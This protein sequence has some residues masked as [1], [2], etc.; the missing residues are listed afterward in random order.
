MAT[1]QQILAGISYPYRV[2]GQGEPAGAKGIDVVRSDLIVLIKTQQRTRVMRPTLGLNLLALVFETTGPLLQSQ[3][4]RE[5]AN[6]VAT[7]LPIVKLNFI[8]VQETD[9]VVT[10]NVFYSVQGLAA[11]TGII[12]FGRQ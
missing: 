4:I 8:D 12:P 2:E 1:T 6:G 5:I 3:I 10:V 11:T 9:K 7:W